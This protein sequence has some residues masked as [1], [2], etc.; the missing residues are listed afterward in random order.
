VVDNAQLLVSEVFVDEL[1]RLLPL[2]VSA[3]CK[4][5]SARGSVLIDNVTKINN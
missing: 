2:P 1:G 4:S 5:R 3:D